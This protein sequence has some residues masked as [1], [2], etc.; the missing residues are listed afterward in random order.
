[1]T[2][3]KISVVAKIKKRVKFCRY[4]ISL[5]LIF[6]YK[7]TLA[8]GQI[9]YEGT[10]AGQNFRLEFLQRLLAPWGFDFLP[11]K[12][13]VFS[14]RRK[15]LYILDPAT[16]QISNLEGAPE[17]WTIKGSHAGYLDIRVRIEHNQPWLY[18][19]YTRKTPAGL[20]LVI[21]KGRLTGNK[22]V[23]QRELFVSNAPSEELEHFGSRFAFDES[24]H[25]YFTFGDRNDR[26]K[27]QDL[28]FHNGKV[29]RLNS[30]GSI[31]HDNPFGD[32]SGADGAVYSYGHRNPQGLVF[33]PETGELWESEF[34][35]K[36]GDE[37]NIIKRGFNYGWPYFTHGTEYNAKPIGKLLGPFGFEES[38]VYYTP[39]ISPSGMAFYTGDDF[40]QWKNNLFLACLSGLQ[41]RRI[42]FH[43]NGQVME[44]EV[45]LGDLKTRFRHLSMGPD[46]Y[47]YFAYEAGLGRFVPIATKAAD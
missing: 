27:V 2:W 12:R 40:P 16:E 19:S 18:W 5:V 31:P 46:G 41:I 42:A 38:V 4:L 15:G 22:V 36:G 28:K 25:I 8:H 14:V 6:L 37:V 10:S 9:F 47:L 43:D 23:E 26:S 39:S 3:L 13:I 24:G 44:Q 33:H 20:V 1:M 7:T 34:G 35:P 45:L 17:A 29:L 11:D 30:N 32:K 21:R